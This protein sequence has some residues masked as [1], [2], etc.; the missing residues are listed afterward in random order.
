[1]L[2]IEQF[3]KASLLIF[4][5]KCDMV[6]LKKICLHIYSWVSNW[7]LSWISVL[8]GNLLKSNKCPALNKHPGEK[9][10]S[11]FCNFVPCFTKVFIFLNSQASIN[12]KF[13]FW[14]FNNC[15]V[16]NKGFLGKKSWKIIRMSCTSIKETKVLWSPYYASM[17]A[18]KNFDNSPAC[19]PFFINM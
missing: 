3:R 14:K 5:G 8:E 9:F 6:I 13:C 18:P 17:L 12:G 19:S 16:F 7:V 2:T 1:M 15:P 10:S 11:I 4:L